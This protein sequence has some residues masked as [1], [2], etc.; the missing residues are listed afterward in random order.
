MGIPKRP[1]SGRRGGQAESEEEPRMQP[2]PAQSVCK[3]YQHNLP[4]V[5]KSLP[6]TCDNTK[7]EMTLSWSILLSRWDQPSRSERCL[8]KTL[9]KQSAST[10]VKLFTGTP[11]CKELIERT[12]GSS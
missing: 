2:H 1:P 9:K 10:E 4:R 12:Q 7:A 6:K 8:T 3:T 11:F 5:V